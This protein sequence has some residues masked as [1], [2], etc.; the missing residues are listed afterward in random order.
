M[1]TDHGTEPQVAPAPTADPR[2]ALFVMIAIDVLAPLAMYYGLRL[3]GISAW[4]AL[5][6]S[7][8]V[9]AVRTV[10]LVISARKLDLMAVFSLLAMTAGT[11]VS[12]LTGS[13]RLI[14]ARDSWITA[15]LGGWLLVLGV[16]RPPLL[17]M[18]QKLMPPASAAQWEHDWQHSA[19]FRRGMRVANGM[20]GVAFLIDAAAR[21]VMAYTL[22]VDSV[23]VLSIGLLVVL[24]VAA[25]QLSLRYGRRL[26]PREP[27]A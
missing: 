15:G 26:M 19:R 6:V 23:Q 27:A 10:H 24:L 25:R 22:P 5:V 21:V 2:R 16:R 17:S 14:L 20:W 11:T 7:G 3:A 4:W 18:T 9:P 12:L 8:V 13:P 1:T